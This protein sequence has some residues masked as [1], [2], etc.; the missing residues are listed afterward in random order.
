MSSS[1]GFAMR[2]FIAKPNADLLKNITRLDWIALAKFYGAEIVT[3]WKKQEIVNAVCDF[4]MTNK[5]LPDHDCLL[6]M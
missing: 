5:V 2:T 1:G 6:L 4:F 3:N